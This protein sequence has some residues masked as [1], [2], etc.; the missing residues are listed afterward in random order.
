MS[1]SLP[2]PVG[3]QKEVLVLPPQG[4]A[5]VL[6]TAGSGKTTLAIHRAL[7]LA[8]PDTDHHG[9]TL[10]VTFNRCLV[11]H[12]RALARP[13]SSMVVVEN[14]HR[15]ARGYL[16]HRGKMRPY[17]ICGPDLQRQLCQRAV[18]EATTGDAPPAVLSRPIDLLVQEF[19]WLAQHGIKTEA[20]YVEGERIGRAGTRIVRGDRPAVF[21]VYQRYLELR[22]ARGKSY[23]WQDLS[24]TVLD[25]FGVD[26]G[27]RKYR[28]V[29]I[30]EGQ[31]FSPMMLRSL[32]AAIPP[33]GSLTLFGDMAQQIYGNRMSWR[34][35][36]LS[37]KDVWEFEENY[38]N[39]RQVAQLA[40]A[41]AEMPNFTDDADLVEPKSPTADGPLP[42]LV[43]FDTEEKEAHFVVQQAVRL[44]KTGTVAVLFRDREQEKAWNSLLPD[45]ATR[46]HGELDRW[47]TSPTG[48]F[49]GTYHSAKGLEFDA[50]ILPRMSQARLPHPPDVTALGQQEAAA[51]DSRLLYV[52]VTR[53][54]STLIL[55]HS[56]DPTG[57]LPTGTDLY[58]RTSR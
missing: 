56:G 50:V 48:I 40:L 46:L 53:S 39:T 6:G 32:A 5:V 30:D 45:R 24:H 25:E 12:L 54:K 11:S 28:H 57:L 18:T 2:P 15:F 3:R 34:S 1:P 23:D 52:A 38:R 43:S 14:Y 49:H 16:S 8:H 31:D 20:E 35:A 22:R 10:L 27:E 36:G 26:D 13:I 17:C 33:D 9:R 19:D 4:H 58:K 41:M 21:G 44:S 42:A 47:P 55:T 7:Y 37:V 29:V 51:R